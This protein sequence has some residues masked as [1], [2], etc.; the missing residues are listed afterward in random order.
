VNGENRTS[1]AARL[2]RRRARVPALHRRMRILGPVAEPGTIVRI[3]NAFRL[4]E[5]TTVP[6]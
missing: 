2:P 4:S 3:L 5:T 6:P 1:F